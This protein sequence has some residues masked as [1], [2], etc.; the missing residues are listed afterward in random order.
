MTLIHAQLHYLPLNKAN[1]YEL[2]SEFC[3]K[4]RVA[5]SCCQKYIRK[6]AIHFFEIAFCSERILAHMDGRVCIL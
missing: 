5:K 3:Y 4:M 6:M 2:T 1:R